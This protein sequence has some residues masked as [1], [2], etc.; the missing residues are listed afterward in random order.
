[1]P[2]TDLDGTPIVILSAE[3]ARALM[4]LIGWGMTMGAPLNDNIRRVA[5]KITRDLEL[6]NES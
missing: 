2:S 5:D 1:M 4:E 6:P 3:E